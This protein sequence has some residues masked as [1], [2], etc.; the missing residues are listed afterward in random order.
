MPLTSVNGLLC[1]ASPILFFWFC[2]FPA[3]SLFEAVSSWLFT[4][5]L[6]LCF[7]SVRSSKEPKPLRF[8]YTKAKQAH[9]KNRSEQLVKKAISFDIFVFNEVEGKAKNPKTL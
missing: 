4:S 8:R 5:A 1:S 3:T 2:C 9:E 6:L 7:G